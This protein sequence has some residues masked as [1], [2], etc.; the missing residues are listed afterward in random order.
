VA[1][2]YEWYSGA[3]VQYE[4]YSGVAV[5]KRWHASA[6]DVAV[7]RVHGLCGCVGCKCVVMANNPWRI[8][9]AFKLCCL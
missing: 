1:V 8:M 7:G 6:W 4:W 9:H 2:Q 5:H 3:A